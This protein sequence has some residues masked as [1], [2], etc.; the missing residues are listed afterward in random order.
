MSNTNLADE[1]AKAQEQQPATEVITVDELSVTD[2]DDVA[3]GLQEP[4]C[5]GMACG[6]Y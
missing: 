4:T 2:L 1:L 3:G 5:K 6:V